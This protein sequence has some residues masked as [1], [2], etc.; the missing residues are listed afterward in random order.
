MSGDGS[1]AGVQWQATPPRLGWLEVG[2]PLWH[3]RW[4]LLLTLVVACL[5]SGILAVLQPVRFTGRA[6]FVVQPVLRPSQTGVTNAIPA[7]AGLVGSGTTAIDQQVAIL[8]S[9]LVADRIAQRFELQRVW[10]LPDASAVRAR[11]MPR[12][13]VVVGRREGVVQILV[14]DEHPQRA[15]ALANEL[16]EE[17][18][19]ILRGFALDE[20]RQR[21]AFYETQLTAART[22]L[23]TARRRLQGAGYDGAA[24]RVEPRGAAEGF[25][26][27]E[28]EIAA[29]EVRLSAARRVRTEGSSEVQQALTELQALRV[30]RTRQA[31][32]RDNESGEFVARMREFRQAELLLEGL[33]RQADAARVDEAAEP[34][35]LQVLDRAAPPPWPSS[36]RPALWV[37]LGATG[38]LLVHAAWIV[39]RHRMAM[40]RNDPRL[41]QRWKE[42]Q[43]VLP[44][45]RRAAQ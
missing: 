7:I 23:D 43:S 32:P 44:R 13:D 31:A 40:A 36:P 10:Q 21:R 20:A 11:L 24:L 45:R 12:I 2:L 27:V 35:P 33:T 19:G 17:L 15:A 3:R 8:R 34:V 9:Q 6:S 28:A 30:Q 5:V 18:R 1:Q 42:V 25:A 16:I 29:A 14:E 38:A 26:R 37:I 41:L 39:A 4:W 22:S